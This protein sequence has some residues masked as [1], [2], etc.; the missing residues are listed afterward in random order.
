MSASGTVFSS[1]GFVEAWCRH[2]GGNLRPFRSEVTGEPDLFG[3]ATVGRTGLLAVDLA[4]EGFCAG[5]VEPPSAAT[6]DEI[7]RQLQKPHI[8]RFEWNVRYDHTV[9]AG[10]LAERLADFKRVRTQSL[11]LSDH[12]DATFAR[13]NATIRNQVRRARRAGV[14]VR[15]SGAGEDLRHYYEIHERL[16]ASKG[17]YGFMFPRAF[18][19]TL[20][21]SLPECRFLTAAVDG[22]IVAGGLFFHDGDSVCYMHGAY[23]RQYSK[24]FPMCAVLDEAIAWAHRLPTTHFNFGGS[25]GIGTLERFKSF[26]GAEMVACWRFAWKNPIWNQ[27]DGAKRWIRKLTHSR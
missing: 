15:V 12:Y 4:P 13:F 24:H 14:V 21:D 5:L 9:L 6:V 27:L 11:R 2:F 23:D 10:H 8:R 1:K 18:L 16:A 19:G 7:L 22:R 26:W 17:G 20:I 3:V 25:A